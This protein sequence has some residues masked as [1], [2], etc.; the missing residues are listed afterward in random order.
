MAIAAH[1]PASSSLLLVENPAMDNPS[2]AG[3]LAVDLLAPSGAAPAGRSARTGTGRPAGLVAGRTGRAPVRAERRAGRRAAVGGHGR[4]A[5][6]ATGRRTGRLGHR[7]ARRSS[8][9]P[10]RP[11]AAWTWRRWSSCGRTDAS[12]AGRAADVLLRSGAYRAGGARSGDE[13]RLAHAPAGPPGA[14]GHQARRRGGL[15][16]GARRPDEASLGSL[17]SL[18]GQSARR[19]S[20][21]GRRFTC[22]LTTL[23]D[24]RR[25]PGWTWQEV[26]HGPEGL[27]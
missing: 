8:S 4:G 27:T 20:R 21:D 2:L 13:R 23:K 5:R 25:G 19:R 1:D 16:D 15:P 3:N 24:K 18:R 7:H 10:M 17:V 6:R 22:R 11:P 9:R 14:A 26:R 12:A